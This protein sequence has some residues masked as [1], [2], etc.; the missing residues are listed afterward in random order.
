[1][2]HISHLKTFGLAV[3]ALAIGSVA[4]ADQ[5]PDFNLA[6]LPNES[7][8]FSNTSTFSFTPITATNLY[9]F[10]VTIGTQTFDGKM[11]GTF[12]VG[13]VNVVTQSATVTG[14]GA[15]DIFDGSTWLTSTLQWVSINSSGTQVGE[16][17]MAAA[18]LTNVVYGGSNATLDA[19]TTAFANPITTISETFI[20]PIK[21]SNL[22]SK[23]A[24]SSFSGTVFY[25]E[26]PDSGATALLI[27][28]G[29]C[30]ILVGVLAQ[31]RKNSMV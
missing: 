20:P 16:N 23:G 14:S 5:D 22:V 31:R 29:G 27:G 9:N 24:S 19:L 3:A 1:M 10:Y 15:F 25:T 4:M 18:N 12:T 21:L 17:Y 28:L 7:I 13:P 8:I 11:T 2:Y 30:G 26:V 6:S